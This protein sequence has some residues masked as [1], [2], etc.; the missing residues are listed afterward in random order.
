MKK[1]LY[2]LHL[3]LLAICTA[4]SCSGELPEAGAPEKGG[5]PFSLTLANKTQTTRAAYYTEQGITGFNENVIKRADVFFYADEN[6]NALYKVS[7]TWNSAQEAQ[8][9][10]SGSIPNDI[11][12]ALFANGKTQCRAYA[13]VNGPTTPKVENGSDTRIAALKQIGIDADFT[14]VTYNGTYGQDGYKPAYSQTEFVM[15][16]ESDINYDA[17]A[18]SM[19]GEIPVDRAASKISLFIT[20]LKN[21]IDDAG[22]VWVPQ[23]EGISVS[24]YYGTN[25]SRIDVSATGNDRAADGYFNLAEDPNSIADNVRFN[26]SQVSINRQDDPA[27]TDNDESKAYTHFPFYSYS[28]DWGR[29]NNPDQE[30]YLTLRIYWTETDGNGNAL[31]ATEPYYYRVPINMLEYTDDN[32]QTHKAKCLERN[33]SYKLMLEVGVLGEKEENTKQELTP[34]YIVVDWKDEPIEAQL[35]DYHYLVVDKN[36]IEMFN[37][38]E[39]VIPYTSCGE[40][41]AVINSISVPDF[42]TNEI[43]TIRYDKSDANAQADVYTVQK[44]AQ[45]TSNIEGSASNLRSLL[46]ACTL[47]LDQ[48]K[49]TVTL[50]HPLQNDNTQKPYDYA[51]YTITIELRTADGCGLSEEIVIK[52]YPARYIEGEDGT[53]PSYSDRGLV[54]INGYGGNNK[55]LTNLNNTWYK[56]NNSLVTTSSYNDNPNMYVITVTSFDGEQ[57]DDFIIADPRESTITTFNDNA[58]NSSSPALYGNSPRGLTY[59][60]ATTH[61]DELSDKYIAPKFRIVSA[62]GRLSGGDLGNYEGL[63]KRC[64]TYQEAGYPAGRWR[65]PTA[66]ELIYVGQLVAD[67]VVPSLFN[68]Q[69]Y[70][71]ASRGSYRFENGNYYRRDK[72]GNSVRCVYDEWYWQDKCDPTVYTWGDAPR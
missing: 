3:L 26:F 41:V 22:N 50:T 47:T 10:L 4:W 64:A 1:T 54:F 49:K 56:V 46:N 68:G 44:G 33:T 15:D 5:I 58:I 24:F 45:G 72:L 36:L 37:E 9:T 32:G 62:Y 31:G 55:D 25:K 20:N 48:A 19:S 61:A 21:Y 71:S 42:S 34:K 16:G 6:A 7:Y 30:A 67:G 2:R 23:T 11:A 57:A 18:K 69:A 35:A 27:T 52:Q 12:E 43:G 63:Q 53:N 60:Y 59:Y 39:L 29:E 28:T 65:V 51:I 13:V 38:T 40:V 66:A 17:D 8:A 14:A 70:Y